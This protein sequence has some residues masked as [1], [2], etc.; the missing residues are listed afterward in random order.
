MNLEYRRPITSHLYFTV[1]FFFFT[2]HACRSN[3]SV[4][5]D[6]H[7]SSKWLI[8]TNPDQCLTNAVP[9]DD[10]FPL[11]ATVFHLSLSF[12]RSYFALHENGWGVTQK[13]QG[14]NLSPWLDLKHI[15]FLSAIVVFWEISRQMCFKCL[16]PIKHC[17]CCCMVFTTI[18]YLLYRFSRHQPRSTS[19]IAVTGIHIHSGLVFVPEAHRKL[20]CMHLRSSR[21]QQTWKLTKATRRKFL[22]FFCNYF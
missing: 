6:K 4:S 13:P 1:K 21:E 18:C 17:R 2:K 3:L 5:V 8:W 7:Y 10:Y 12:P 16:E 11:F 9:I 20:L 14:L 19:Y 15:Y 22:L